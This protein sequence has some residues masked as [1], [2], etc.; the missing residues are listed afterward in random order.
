LA[1]RF[2][3]LAAWLAG[4]WRRRNSSPPHLEFAGKRLRRGHESTDMGISGP[5]LDKAE[6]D[7]DFQAI[8]RLHDTILRARRRSA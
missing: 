4:L 5:Q 3:R 7:E 1:F 2:V 6:I 8:V